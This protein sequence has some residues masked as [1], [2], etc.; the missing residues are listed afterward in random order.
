MR[1]YAYIL[2]L[3]GDGLKKSAEASVLNANFL[4]KLLSEKFEI[5]DA[6]RHC[7]HEFVLSC[8]RLA[9]ETGVTATDIAKRAYR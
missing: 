2:T 3:G 6:G 7:M 5:S 8:E 9:Q 1:A 4:K